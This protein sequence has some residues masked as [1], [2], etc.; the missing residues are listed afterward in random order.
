MLDAWGKIALVEGRVYRDQDG[1]PYAVRR[2]TD[3]TILPEAERGSYREARGA[4]P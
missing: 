4:V 2:I 3:V 1:H